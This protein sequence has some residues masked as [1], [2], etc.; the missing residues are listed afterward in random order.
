MCKSIQALHESYQTNHQRSPKRGYGKKGDSRH[1]WFRHLSRQ[2][3]P[4]GYSISAASKCQFLQLLR[5]IIHSY[6]PI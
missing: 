1:S 4:G 3:N 2:S 6:A 5:Y